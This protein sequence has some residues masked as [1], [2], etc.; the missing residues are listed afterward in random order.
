ME[1]LISEKTNSQIIKEAKEAFKGQW[2]RT[3]IMYLLSFLI[4][5][6]SLVLGLIIP[7]IIAGMG[8]LIFEYYLGFSYLFGNDYPSIFTVLLILLNI[9][10]SIVISGR[11]FLWRNKFILE[12]SRGMKPKIIDLKYIFK[13][14]LSDTTEKISFNFFAF[15]IPGLTLALYSLILGFGFIMLIIPGIIFSFMYAMFPF[16]LVDEHH[17]GAKKYLNRSN[18]IMSGKKFKLFLCR[19]RLL[20]LFILCTLP[21]GLGLFWFFPFGSF[22]SAKFYDAHK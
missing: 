6:I 3:F 22:V 7:G 15:V 20:P 4:S 10:I 17:T 19:L 21:F 16:V 13:G 12:S 5:I 11:F 9:F 14:Q 8:W 18:T 2:G 1:T